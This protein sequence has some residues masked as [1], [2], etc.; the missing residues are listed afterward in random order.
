MTLSSRQ[1]I[2]ELNTAKPNDLVAFGHYLQED[3]SVP[4]PILWRVLERTDN[5]LFL[6]SD[7]ILDCR[8]YHGKT[9][10][11]T[12]RDAVDIT[13]QDCDLRDWL[14]Q[15][16]FETAFDPSEKKYIQTV[17][18]QDNGEGSPDT[19]DK[20][21]LLS[22]KEVLMAK[23]VLGVQGLKTTGTSYAKLKK[24]DGS[25]LYVYDLSKEADY[26]VKEGQRMGCSWW[27]LR[28]QGNK[29]SRAYFIGT[30]ASLRSYAN[31]S[32]AR[33]GIRPAIKIKLD[34]N[35]Q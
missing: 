2:V 29:A 34:S 10:E 22:V 9:A 5:E 6:L 17:L 27:W 18:C 19:N 31:V 13:W 25:N 15:E 23:D 7:L 24:E 12:W 14:N 28:T 26:L 4:S 21:F 3:L 32:C 33:D 16:F 35:H 8:R 1:N 11:V 30:Q 20:V